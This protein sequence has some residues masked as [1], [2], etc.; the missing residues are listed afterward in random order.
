[1]DLNALFGTLLSEESINGMGE[2]AGASAGD[3][4]SV[5]AAALP[6]MLNGA[7]GQASNPATAES[8]FQA[9]NDHAGRDSDKVDVVEGENQK[10]TLGDFF[11][12]DKVLTTD[13]LNYYDCIELSPNY[14][15]EDTKKKKNGK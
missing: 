8:F 4:V 14:V 13:E 15:T 1:M 7:N 10:G 2:K 5:L 9:V 3:A 11:L 12:S 6:S